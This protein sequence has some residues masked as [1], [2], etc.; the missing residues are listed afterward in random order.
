MFLRDVLYVP[1]LAYSLLSV[2]KETENGITVCFD[3]SG[4][5]IFDRKD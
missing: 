4:C 2:S 5:R 3:D 1:D